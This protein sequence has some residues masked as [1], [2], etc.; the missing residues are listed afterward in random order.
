VVESHE[1]LTRVANWRQDKDVIHNGELTHFIPQNNVYVYF[2]HNDEETVMV[3]LNA[4]E[5]AQELEMGRFSELI[6]GHT[7][8]YDVAN[9]RSVQLGE[10]MSV[11]GLD[12]MI[13]ELE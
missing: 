6:D 8:G 11:D 12:A 13:L 2:R 3:V 9:D 10:T 1:F 7:Q 5:E 4:N